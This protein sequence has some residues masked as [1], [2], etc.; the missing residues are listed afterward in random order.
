[1][2]RQFGEAQ[3]QGERPVRTQEE[4]ERQLATL[5]RLGYPALAGLTPAELDALVRPVLA[6]VR[7][8]LGEELPGDGGIPF[9]LVVTSA[10]VPTVDAVERWSVRGRSG[11]TDMAAELPDYRPVD[12]LEAPADPVYALLDVDTGA[13]TLG[14][15]PQDALPTI[16]GAGRQPLTIDEGVALVTQLPD[17]FDSHNAFQALGSR[18]PNRRVP[19]FWFSKGAPRLGWCWAGN[20]HSWLGAGSTGGRL[21][22]S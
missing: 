13:G 2:H 3:E 14:V 5:H 11:W 12:G 21:A 22:A 19:S 17:V 18:A 20:P 9:L 10:L 16:V 4:G 7:E 6:R 8:R 1:M 15:T